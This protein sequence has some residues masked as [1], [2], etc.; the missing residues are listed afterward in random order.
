V[1][2][3]RGGTLAGV[4]EVDRPDEEAAVSDFHGRRQWNPAERVRVRRNDRGVRAGEHLC[5]VRLAVAVRI[6]PD[7]HGQRQACRRPTVGEM[8]GAYTVL[9]VSHSEVIQGQDVPTAGEADAVLA[10]AV[11][12]LIDQAAADLRD[13]ALVGDAVGLA[14]GTDVAV[15]VRVGRI[16]V[17]LV[18][19]V[20]AIAVRRQ[21]Q[22][23]VTGI[24]LAVEIAVVPGLAAIRHTVGVAIRGV[25]GQEVT[26]VL[27]AVAVAIDA[28]ARRQ[29]AAVDAVAVLR[30][31]H[32]ASAIKPA[33]HAG[34]GDEVKRVVLHFTVLEHTTGAGR[35]IVPDQADAQPRRTR[36]GPGRWVDLE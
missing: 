24:E 6:A 4:V 11:V 13:I 2:V 31:L 28:A 19:H 10:G 20:V 12:P 35:R 14:V 34:H 27:H 15:A 16:E 8:H 7:V 23:D 18:G 22:G 32:G 29:G 36:Q 3:E 17:A 33:A 5:V 21:A 30:K 25:A 26:G 1:L 9:A